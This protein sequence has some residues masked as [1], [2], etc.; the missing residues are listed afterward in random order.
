MRTASVAV[1]GFL[2]L[3]ILLCSGCRDSSTPPPLTK[4]HL[5]NINL[6]YSNFC[7]TNGRPPSNFDELEPFVV[8][9]VFPESRRKREEE[10]LRELRDGKYVVIWN[11]KGAFGARQGTEVLVAYEQQTPERGGFVVFADGRVQRMSPEELERATQGN[12]QAER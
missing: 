7:D 11:Q 3:S 9:T 6:A 2:C 1:T 5:L 12:D 4:I 8:G 10:T